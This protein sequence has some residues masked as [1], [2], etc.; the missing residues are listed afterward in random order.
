MGCDFESRMGVEDN[1]EVDCGDSDEM[2]WVEETYVGSVCIV[3]DEP[4]GKCELRTKGNKVD[5]PC[6]LESAF[7][8]FE[9]P[10]SGSPIP[11]TVVCAHT[12]AE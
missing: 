6:V 4:W 1:C 2:G 10:F 12:Y 8:E 5:L 9:L 3:D 7:W 11:G